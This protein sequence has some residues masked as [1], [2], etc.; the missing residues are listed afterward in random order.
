MARRRRNEERTVD[1]L[2]QAALRVERKR[3]AEQRAETKRAAKVAEIEKKMKLDSIEKTYA[4]RR[5]MIAEQVKKEEK[6]R[7]IAKYAQKM[8]VEKM[9]RELRNA[10]K[11]RIQDLVSQLETQDANDASSDWTGLDALQ[12]EGP[13][14][15]RK[16]ARDAGQILGRQCE[17]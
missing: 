8:E 9:A 11:K 7:K 12:L 1:K 15:R 14:S 17:G 3:L 4:E 2:F 5:R 10:E 6:D 16:T 13:T